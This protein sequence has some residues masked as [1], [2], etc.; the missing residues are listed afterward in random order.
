MLVSNTSLQSEE[1]GLLGEMADS[2]AGAAKYMSLE[3][4]G[5]SESKEGLQNQND[6]SMSEEHRS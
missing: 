5:M 6:R 1:P 3:H 4:L 2:R